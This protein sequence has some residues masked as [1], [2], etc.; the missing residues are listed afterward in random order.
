[1]F[2]PFY[3]FFQGQLLSS[4]ISQKLVPILG[5]TGVFLFGNFVRGRYFLFRIYKRHDFGKPTKTQNPAGPTCRR[6]P[7]HTRAASGVTGAFVPCGTVRHWCPHADR[8]GVATTRPRHAHSST[9]SYLHPARSQALTLA[10]FSPFLL[11]VHSSPPVTLLRLPIH[12]RHQQTRKLFLLLP[13]QHHALG[14]LEQGNFSDIPRARATVSLS[15]H[16]FTTPVRSAPLIYA[17]HGAHG[18]NAPA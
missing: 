13:G 11:P 15:L 4:L 2:W 5:I 14:W 9:P 10:S 7:P 8:N 18:T 1:M 6:L 3:L 17:P 12:S 16:R